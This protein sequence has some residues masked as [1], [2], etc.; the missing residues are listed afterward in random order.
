MFHEN[1]NNILLCKVCCGEN[2]SLCCLFWFGF[3][4]CDPREQH[5]DMCINLF[6]CIHC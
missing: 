5:V 4:F 3:C 1:I 6:L 2:D